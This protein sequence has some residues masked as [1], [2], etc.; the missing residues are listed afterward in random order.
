MDLTKLIPLPYRILIGAAL[1]LGVVGGSFAFGYHSGKSKGQQIV[2]KYITKEVQVAS[3]AKSDNAD[4]NNAATVK[5]VDRIKV[6]HDINTVYVN[7]ASND[8]PAQ[9]QLSN[10]W[11]YL[12]N[13]AANQLPI[14][15]KLAADATP[16]GVMDNKALTTI[17]DNYS[18]C[19]IDREKLRDLQQS[20]VDWT[21]AVNKDAKK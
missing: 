3:D 14:D 11:V 9:N 10:G 17:A 19:E 7:V 16:S 13:Q 8:V 18:N 4:V 1:F 20:I 15:P 21:A 5:Y 2:T 6:V 12:H